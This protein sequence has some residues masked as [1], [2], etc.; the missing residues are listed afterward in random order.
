MGAPALPAG[1]KKT[2]TP[3]KSKAPWLSAQNMRTAADVLQLG[4]GLLERNPKARPYAAAVR[5][6][7]TLGIA[8]IPEDNT[9]VL[10]KIRALRTELRVYESRAE[11]TAKEAQRAITLSG[12]IFALLDLLLES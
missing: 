5:V 1:S 4:L 3:K 10:E 11:L 2:K 8:A 9:L 7:T 12:Q 6:A